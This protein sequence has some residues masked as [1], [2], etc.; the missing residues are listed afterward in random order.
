MR[1][2]LIAVLP[3]LLSAVSATYYIDCDDGKGNHEKYQKHMEPKER[4]ECRRFNHG[5][6]NFECYKD[7]DNKYKFEW[8]EDDNCGKNGG[9]RHDYD[10]NGKKGEKKKH[11]EGR[12]CWSY[13]VECKGKDK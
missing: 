4:S 13:R 5:M 8:Y 1:L 7:D 2:S 3:L 12:P 11:G 9:K 10:Y 6:K